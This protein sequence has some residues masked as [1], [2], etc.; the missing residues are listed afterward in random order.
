VARYGLGVVDAVAL[1]VLAIVVGLAAGIARGGRLRNVARLRVD[2]PWLLGVGV[3]VPALVSRF[4][5]PLGVPLVMAAL[6][7]LLAFAVANLRLVGMTIVAIGIAANLAVLVVNA[8]MPV[9]ASALVHAGLAHE[10]ELG[11]VE[12]RGA[13]R[14]EHPGDRLMFLADIVPFSP[15]RQV[16]S[17]GDLIVLVGAA[18]VAANLT[19]RRRRRIASLSREAHAALISIAPPAD[20]AG[21]AASITLRQLAQALRTGYGEPAA[22]VIDLRDRERVEQAR[23]DATPIGP[24]V[25]N[26]RRAVVDLDEIVIEDEKLTPTGE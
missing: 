11:N 1:S 8:G 4:D 5:P 24:P 6:V 15:T 21:T 3:I 10:H 25:R 20:R 13:Q 14:L 19:L 23:R 18:D 26:R 16:L 9:R 7:A 22:G 12:I 17:F 2:L